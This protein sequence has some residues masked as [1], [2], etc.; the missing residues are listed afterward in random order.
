MLSRYSG[1]LHLRF[2]FGTQCWAQS[3]TVEEP[4]CHTFTPS[5]S[6]TSHLQLRRW[7]PAHRSLRYV[8]TQFD[9][10]V[11]SAIR[12]PAPLDRR[13]P[14]NTVCVNTL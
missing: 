2:R 5:T 6:P 3:C 8:L 14:A 7:K 4:N 11:T 13:V 12:P 9:L 1:S 10:R